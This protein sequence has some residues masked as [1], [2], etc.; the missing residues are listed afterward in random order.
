MGKIPTVR[1]TISD[2]YTSRWEIMFVTGDIFG[3]GNGLI[4]QGYNIS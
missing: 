4:S 1:R 3:Q 2:G